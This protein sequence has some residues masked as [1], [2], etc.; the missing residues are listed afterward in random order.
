MKQE[1]TSPRKKN[2]RHKEEEELL[3]ANIPAEEDSAMDP[4]FLAKVDLIEKS[5]PNTELEIAF[6]AVLKRKE[7]HVQKLVNEIAKLKGFMSKR[8]QTYKRKRKDEGAPTRAL[9]AYNIY[10]QDRFARLAKENDAALKST[11]TNIKMQRVPPSNLV[12][13][14]GN[15]WKLL[16]QSEKDKYEERAKADKKRYEEQMAKY[17][18]PDKQ[19]NRKR[20]KTGYNMFFSAHV[21]RL[22]QSEMGVPSERGSVAR[23]VGNAWK[24]LTTEEKQYYE[25][26]ADKH[27]GMNPLET[28]IS[29]EEEDDDD[30]NTVKREQHSSVL[31]NPLYEPAAFTTDMPS[32]VA[33]TGYQPQQQQ[34]QQHLQMQH[35][36]RHAHGYYYTT[37]G[38]YDYTDFPS[39]VP[40][41][42]YCLHSQQFF[43]SKSKRKLEFVHIPKTGGTVIESVA[44][45]QGID[46]T[47]CHFLP[48]ES[49]AEMSMDIIQCPESDG[50]QFLQWRYMQ[51]FHGL[52]WW[53]VPPSY[54]FNYRDWLPGNPYVNSDLFAVV[55]D[56][57][58]R[59]ISEYYYQQ[60]WLVSPEQK[61]QTQDVKY[62]NQWIKTKLE[63]YSHFSCDRTAKR[64]LFKKSNATKSYLSFDGHLIS[65]YD[66]IYDNSAPTNASPPKKI[67]KHVLRFESLHQDFEALVLEYGLSRLAPLPSDHVRKSLPKKLGLYNMTLDNFH[68]IERVYRL[69]FETFGYEIKSSRVPS[70]ILQRNQHL[71]KCKT[72]DERYKLH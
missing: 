9:S 4:E 1:R 34:Q 51:P 16:P 65:Q 22:K 58:S 17:H 41:E 38:Y 49:V 32:T 6:S 26:E 62:F 42:T 71:V 68:L 15:E 46:W 69:D 7:E 23:L 39:T 54:F 55:R 48:S 24:S 45:K 5:T 3:N 2:I 70:E 44:A 33:T 31:N 52:V 36:P 47:I 18:P 35:D 43:P 29:K 21:L 66:Y 8:K 13:S 72:P 37:H 63:L 56:P 67:V 10:I 60:S 28:I 64:E 53:H 50:K 25:R 19:S 61:A 12:A 20:N 57:Y 59:L 30:T 40:A 27:N 11:D 14:T